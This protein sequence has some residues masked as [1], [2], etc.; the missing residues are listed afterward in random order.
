MMPRVLMI[1]DRYAPLVGGS[2]RQ[3]QLLVRWLHGHDVPV[4]VLTRRVL[5][6]LPRH[7][8]IDGIHV[9]RLP[10]SGIGRFWKEI[11][12]SL[13][14]AWVLIRRAKSYDLIHLHSGTSFVGAVAIGISRFLG[15]P[16]ILK[17]A[18]AGDIRKSVIET[19]EGDARP[20]RMH[21][22]FNRFIN[23]ML[24]RAHTI[25]C[26]SKEIHEEL[27]VCGFSPSQLAM[28]PNGV[29]PSIYSPIRQDERDH[30]RGQLGLPPKATI[31][32]YTGRLIRRKGVDLLLKAWAAVSNGYPNAL[33]LLVGS[34]STSLD[35]VEEELRVYVRKH[36]LET[37]VR[38]V[39]EQP[40][41]LKYLQ[42]ADL[43]VF[44]SRRE[45]MSN[46]LLEAM[47]VGLPVLASSIG[48]NV[49]LVEHQRNGWLFV[50]EQSLTLGIERL[51]R[52]PQFRS[53][54]GQSA[55]HTIK[56]RYSPNALFPRLLELYQHAIKT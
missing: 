40:S 27:I 44:P 2:E 1:I 22:I 49:D 12:F 43:F 18:T 45:G 34:G 29:D 23:R 5:S 9:R 42:A 21:R 24:T 52:D 55:Q 35:S 16:A 13:M 39:G 50:D 31:A 51:L 53:R 41:S 37:T 25:V 33:L 6:S 46:S 15:K 32:L 10:P 28:I 19:T 36:L 4:E 56:Q 38:F 26:I 20:S 7:E 48:G 30:L 11:G 47:S 54:L 17:I 8:S 14:L 3:C